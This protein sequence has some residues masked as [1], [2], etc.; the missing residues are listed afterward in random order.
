MV[1]RAEK[2]ERM[3]ERTGMKAKR[4]GDRKM[5]GW[6]VCEKWT[7]AHNL[8]L[9]IWLF[10][11]FFECVCVCVCFFT[12]CFN[13]VCKMATFKNYIVVRIYF[14]DHVP[15]TYSFKYSIMYISSIY[16]YFDVILLSLRTT[17]RLCQGPRVPCHLK[18]CAFCCALLLL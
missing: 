8:T 7:I 17:A 3:K 16:F 4:L 9:S 14:S 5:C 6:H 12:I 15:L 11:S 1:G 10:R 13:W 2:K 18:T